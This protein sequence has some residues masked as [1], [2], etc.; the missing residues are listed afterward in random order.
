YQ[1]N[2]WSSDVTGTFSLIAEIEL[3][4]GSLIQSEAVSFEVQEDTGGTPSVCSGEGIGITSPGLTD[5]H[6]TVNTSGQANIQ[7]TPARAGVAQSTIIVVVNGA[8]YHMQSDGNGGF[9]HD[10]ISNEGTIDFYFVYD[11]PEGGERNS[12]ANPFSC[13]LSGAL[14]QASTQNLVESDVTSHFTP[15]SIYPN[16]VE[17]IINFDGSWPG[18]S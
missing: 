2:D 6:Y 11:V 1:L 18:E 16:P 9:T 4:D 5:F 7:F 10:L 8:G 14:V 15:I 12:S 13:T 17:E 3:S